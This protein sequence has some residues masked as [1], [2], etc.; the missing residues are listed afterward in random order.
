[1]TI[2][3]DNLESRAKAESSPIPEWLANVE[4]ALLEG[5]SF[6]KSKTWPKA[7]LDAC[8]IGADLEKAKGPFLIAVLTWARKSFDH[9][10]YPSVLVVIDRAI[11]LW[12]RKDIGSTE[13][14]N[15]ARAALRQAAGTAVLVEGAERW[16]AG[17]AA[18]AA[19]AGEAPAVS[20]VSAAAVMAEVAMVQ[21][22]GPV[23][24]AEQARLCDDLADQ[25]IAILRSV[26]P[27]GLH[28]GAA[29]TS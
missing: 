23:A 26:E 13:W 20:A 2:N 19:M 11:A 28:H 4:E 14:N 12:Q 29:S 22:M 15:E 24:R 3:L 9:E 21:D 25:I 7:F 17:A 8:H 1:M 16:A 18:A 10:R 5:M 27:S 6:E